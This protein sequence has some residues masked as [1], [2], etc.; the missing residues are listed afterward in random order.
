MSDKLV[1]ETLLDENTVLREFLGGIPDDLDLGS[2][3]REAFTYLGEWR[4]AMKQGKD[5]G[6]AYRMGIKENVV[7]SE[8]DPA[9]LIM[10]FVNP[11]VE[12]GTVLSVEDNKDLIKNI[13]TLVSMTS[14]IQQ[15]RYGENSVVCTLPPP[16][17][18]LNELLKDLG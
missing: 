5:Y 9:T 14:L 8:G 7:D 12:R 3:E 1:L 13:K 11:L 17:Y 18:M 4:S 2:L 6:F 16:E 10:Y 15:M